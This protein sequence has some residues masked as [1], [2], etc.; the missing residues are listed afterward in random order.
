MRDNEG[1]WRWVLGKSF[2][3]VAPSF[4]LGKVG[5]SQSS[6]IPIPTL[7][8]EGFETGLEDSIVPTSK[9]F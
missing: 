3:H 6:R 8:T 4:T 7:F 9:R 1:F 5:L 2:D